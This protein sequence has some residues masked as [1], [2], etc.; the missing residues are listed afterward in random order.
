VRAA[1]LPLPLREVMAF[2]LVGAVSSVVHFGIVV[3]LVQGGVE[4]LAANVAGFLVAFAV[5]FAGHE[6][7]SFPSARRA[8]VRALRRFFFVALLS[9][10]ANEALYWWLL[11]R[12]DLAYGVALVIVLGAVGALTLA[13]AKG[14]AFS[15]AAA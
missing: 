9:F 14:W 2:T 11:E 3:G 6:R 7:W 8:R 1:A 10:G 12:T 5:S 13:L 15:D 4:P